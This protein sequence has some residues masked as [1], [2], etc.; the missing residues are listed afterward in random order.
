M[1]TLSSAARI[2]DDLASRGVQMWPEGEHLR[3]R[4]PAGVLDAEDRDRLREHK[5]DILRELR[6]RSATHPF[7]LEVEP[8]LAARNEP[9]PLTD[10]QQAYWI[11]RQEAFDLG[12]VAIHYY[13]EVDCRNLDLPRLERAWNRVV[14]RHDML[15]A[16]VHAVGEQQILAEVPDYEIPVVDLRNLD[17]TART[18]A[19]QAC[20]DEM[21]HRVPDA[22]SWPC[23]AL[24]AHRLEEDS[25]RLHVSLDLLHVDGAS[26]LIL[27]EDWIRLY[28]DEEAELEPLEL[29][30]RDYVQ[31]E[32]RLA[33]SPEM[34]KGLAWW[35]DKVRQLPPAPDLPLAVAPSRLEHTRFVRRVLEVSPDVFARLKERATEIGLTPTAFF[36]T[37]FSETLRAYAKAA[38]FTLNVTLFNRLP[39]HPQ[40]NRL[41]GD[42]TSMVLLADRARAGEALE[43]HARRL[44]V[45]LWEAL[46]HRWVSGVKVLG[47]LNRIQKSSAGGVMPIVFT[48]L[49]DLNTQGFAADVL[50]PL[51]KEIYTITQTP[52]V[53]LDHQVRETPD[54]GVVLSWDVV[55]DLFADGMVEEMLA[56]YHRLL[57]RLVDEPELWRG[58]VPGVV[59]RGE[60]ERRRRLNDTAAPIPETTLYHLFRGRA[61]ADP[62]AP[63]VL[64]AD[65]TLTYGELDRSSRHLGLRLR[66]AGAE[67]DRLVAVSMEKGWQQVL[68]SVAVHAAGSAYLPVDPALPRERRDYLLRNGE[69]CAVLTSGSAADGGGPWPDGVEVIA[70]DRFLAGSA[71]AEEPPELEPV[72][73]PRHL[74]HVIYTSGSTGMPKGVMVEHRSV[75]NRMLDIVE[76]FQIGPGD[77]AL[78]LTALH[79]DLSVFDIFGVLTAGAAVVLPDEE[80][81]RDPGVW[82]ELMAEHGVTLW[83]SVP[84]FL[85]MLLEYV[86]DGAAEE[87]PDGLRW[88]ILAG[89]WIPVSLPDRAR[90]L[91]PELTFIASGG[92]TETCIWDIWNPVGEVD[93]EWPSIPY[94]KPLKNAVYH[95]L[96]H[97]LEHRPTGVAG[98]MYIGGAGLARGYWK[99]PER[100]AEKFIVHPK[101][102]ERLYRSGDWG[103]YLPDGNLEF[104]GRQDHQVKIQGQRIE[105]GEIE[106]ALT[107]HPEVRAAVASVQSTD[108]GMRLVA[109]VVPRTPLAGKEALPGKETATSPDAASGDGLR[110]S[111]TDEYAAGGVSVVDPLERVQ[112]KLSYR[113]LRRPDAEDTVVDLPA[114]DLTAVAEAFARTRSRRQWAPGLDLSAL[115]RFLTELSFVEEESSLHKYRYGSG[116]GLYP[117]QL[118]LAVAPESSPSGGVSGLDAGL[119]YYH[120]GAHRLQR[121][122]DLPS[123]GAASLHFA[124]NREMAEQAALQIFLVGELDAVEPMYGALARDFC[125]LEAGMMCQVMREIADTSGVAVCQVGDVRTDALAE[126][127]GLSDRRLFLHGLLAGATAADEPSASASDEGAAASLSP[128][129]LRTRLMEHLR[130]KLPEHMVPSALAFLDELPLTANGKVDRGRLTEVAVDEV[131]AV[132]VP[133]A[134]ELEATLAALWCEALGLPE[135]SVDANFFDLGANSLLAGK[136]F[137]QLCRQLGTSFPLITIFRKPTVRSLAE[138]LGQE[139]PHQDGPDL[140]PARQRAE[141][142]LDRRRNR[143]RRRSADEKEGHSE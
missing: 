115:G 69:V 41:V 92:P 124:A 94:G 7:R 136:V 131:E 143:R 64:T 113:A 87:V 129:V 16:V 140:D 29:S 80:G 27:F 76:R 55:E 127:L 49:L 88:I 141:K 18:E 67:P 60:M 40:V 125:L 135:I 98:E 32:H 93:P 30:Y 110:S 134:N 23:F 39:V 53:Y 4:S 119:Y 70:V 72:Q 63:A 97:N 78:G 8:D 3:L 126:A 82:L 19:L 22:A 142:R 128:D 54:G 137:R 11:G 73:G 74:S 56:A 5:E 105:L 65:H 109:R 84:A 108:R 68:A 51:G 50:A 122:G 89:D 104:M 96:D 130:A 14:R 35:R 99:D 79:H 61:A 6:R 138:H 133:P 17:E 90:A 20:R 47:E 43:D 45:D 1:K 26:I 46:E 2:L 12:D 9:F 48:S 31:A 103:R 36:L 28:G 132:H 100:T 116:G 111:S 101:T 33:E 10:I 57:H 81:R 139:D 13:T 37:A 24:R 112:F 123:E 34:E 75:V 121:V 44:Q 95:V 117:V 59:S 25:V 38:D 62:E 91:W 71:V 118:Y 86:E 83:N 77:K 15:R 114:R 102:G 85:E 120:P 21:S 42:F 106:A 52:Q 58:P 66:Q 107:S